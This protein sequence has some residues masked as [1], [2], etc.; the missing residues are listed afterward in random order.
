MVTRTI[1]ENSFSGNFEKF[2]RKE[3]EEKKKEK[4]EECILIILQPCDFIKSGF[5]KR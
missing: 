4:P 5:L 1:Q 2:Q 3:N